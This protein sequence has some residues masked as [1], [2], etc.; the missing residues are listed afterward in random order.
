MGIPCL[1]QLSCRDFTVALC[2]IWFYLSVAS[3]SY[4]LQYS[5]HIPVVASAVRTAFIMVPLNRS[6]IP[7]SSWLWGMICTCVMSMS[8][9]TSSTTDYI[10]CSALSDMK[11]VGGFPKLYC[12]LFKNLSTYKCGRFRPFVQWSDVHI[13]IMY[14]YE[15]DEVYSKSAGIPC[16]F[17][18]PI[19]SEQT[20]SPLL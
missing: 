19:M 12:M 17:N 6:A 3:A 18:G 8:P 13:E 20:A 5:Q 2:R 14:F 7:L 4:Q 1:N 15:R 16:M 10:Y 9:S 11:H